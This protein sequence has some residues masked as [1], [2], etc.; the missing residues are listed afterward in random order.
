M[1]RISRLHLLVSLIACFGIA[2]FV[3]SVTVEHITFRRSLVDREARRY[4]AVLEHG[5]RQPPRDRS[6]GE[7]QWKTKRRSASS[8]ATKTQDKKRLPPTR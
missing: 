5:H 2:Q 8:Q 6:Q 3:G 1:Q 4:M 7:E